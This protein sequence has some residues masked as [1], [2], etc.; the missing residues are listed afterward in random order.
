MPDTLAQAAR[1]HVCIQVKT[2]HLSAHRSYQSRF[3]G[4]VHV[5]G[6][7]AENLYDISSTWTTIRMFKSIVQDVIDDVVAESIVVEMSVVAKRRE[8]ATDEMEAT[9]RPIEASASKCCYG[10][11]RSIRH[12]LPAEENN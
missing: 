1:L 2:A 9:T 7:R 3:V 11:G 6:G 8:V 12:C 10:Q 4:E 5:G